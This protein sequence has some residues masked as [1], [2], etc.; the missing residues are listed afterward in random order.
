MSARL[1][2][3]R[4]AAAYCS[5]PVRGF[6]KAVGISP[7]RLGSHEL[8]D[9]QRLDAYIDGLQGLTKNRADGWAS[10]VEKF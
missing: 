2:N 6:R 3:L 9:R 10:A 8:W 4:D 1:L 5:L 7:V